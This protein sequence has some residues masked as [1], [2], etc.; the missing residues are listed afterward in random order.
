MKRLLEFSRSVL[1]PFFRSSRLLILIVFFVAGLSGCTSSRHQ[2]QPLISASGSGAD[3]GKGQRIAILAEQGG[4]VQALVQELYELFAARG[5][6]QLVDRSNLHETMQERRFQQ[7]S[8]VDGRS[9]G[10]IAGADVMIYVQADAQS[11]RAAPDSFLGSILSPYASETVVN[12]VASFRAIRPET[13]EIV[14]ARRLDLSDKK[15]SFTT[16]TFNPGVNPA[17]LLETLR[18]QAALLIYQSLHP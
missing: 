7:M 16:S 14:A 4:D 11:G 6:Y 5:Y 2:T 17:P 3:L 15:G 1:T 10:T 9:A 13:G 12:Y 8:F 18:Q